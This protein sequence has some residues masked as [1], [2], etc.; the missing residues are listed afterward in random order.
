MDFLLWSSFVSLALLIALNFG[1]WFLKPIKV[2]LFTEPSSLAPWHQGSFTLHFLFGLVAVQR[3]QLAVCL[4][5]TQ[6]VIR[7]RV[8]P[9]QATLPCS[10]LKSWSTIINKRVWTYKINC[11]FM[12]LEKVIRQ[13]HFNLIYICNF[14]EGYKAP[15]SLTKDVQDFYT[16]NYKN[17]WIKSFG[18]FSL[19]SS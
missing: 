18:R 5:F 13:C 17:Y 6:L 10:G 9:I 4:D 16:E 8:H 14:M 12:H 19:L 7:R 1:S 2:C 15:N 3:L 11:M